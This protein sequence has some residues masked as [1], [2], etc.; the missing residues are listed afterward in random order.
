MSLVA[1]TF[2]VLSGCH[3][4]RMKIRSSGE[5]PR[6]VL[7]L[8]EAWET[9][10]ESCCAHGVS[11]PEHVESSCSPSHRCKTQIVDAGPDR[12]G[13]RLRLYVIGLSAGP[14][15]VEVR[16]RQLN[17]DEV[18][19]EHVHLEFVATPAL[20]TLELG[21]GRPSGPFKYEHLSPALLAH[22]IKA[23]ARCE[24]EDD[25]H[26]LYACFSAE[27]ILGELRY[28]SCKHTTRCGARIETGRFQIGLGR[29]RSGRIRHIEMSALTDN[30][31]EE[32]GDWE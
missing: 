18:L 16:Y 4:E 29:G 30:G 24:L 22:G 1:A 12:S 14:V 31:W 5:A 15:D 32:L 6:E 3:P 10:L 28:L 21:M 20:P 27:R 9:P 7:T 8:E 23:P 19:T 13:S 2:V 26:E 25:F 11:V 17:F